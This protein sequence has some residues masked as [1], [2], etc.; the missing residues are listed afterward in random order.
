MVMC[1]DLRHIIEQSHL[2][3]SSSGQLECMF[4][5]NIMYY[6][7]YCLYLQP[8]MKSVWKA[9]DGH[10]SFCWSPLLLFICMDFLYM[11]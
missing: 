2:T 10:S 5:I 1:A 9:K 11:N 6:T 4:E 8:I 3:V 7:D